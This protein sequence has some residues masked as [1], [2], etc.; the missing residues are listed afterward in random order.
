MGALIRRFIGVFTSPLTVHQPHSLRNRATLTAAGMVIMTPD[1]QTV[2]LD[3]SLE[4][5]DHGEALV[6]AAARRLGFDED[7]L[8]EIGV[9][10]RETLV[11]A[12]AHGNRYSS[13]KK[14]LIGINESP[15]RLE[16][17]I[18]DEGSGFDTEA[19]RD[20]LDTGNLLRQSGRGLLMIR[21][22][23]DEVSVGPRAATAQGAAAVDAKPSP[24]GG[25]LVRM[26]KLL[27]AH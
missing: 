14:V 19:I 7:A 2:P 6:L 24:T 4:G 1:V 3:S 9:A 23:M 16:I 13:K 8:H 25:T 15:G 18:A 27:P 17:E 11:N 22:Y 26:V 20:P 5:V 21:A 12:V 10:V